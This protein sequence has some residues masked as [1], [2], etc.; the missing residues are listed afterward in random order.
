MI[1][2]YL[3]ECLAGSEHSVNITIIIHVIITVKW[4]IAVTGANGVL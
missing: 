3:E 2:Q 4:F 1:H